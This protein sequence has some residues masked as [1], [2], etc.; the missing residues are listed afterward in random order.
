MNASNLIGLINEKMKKRNIDIGKIDIQRNF[1]FFE[2]D[3][4]YDQK[5]LNAFEGAVYE[6]IPINIQIS[7]PEKKGKSTEREFSRKRGS[8]EYRSKNKNKKKKR[9][10]GKNKGYHRSH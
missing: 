7:T 2:I 1:S 9:N 3:K 6:N 10:P 5:I 8:S 4:D